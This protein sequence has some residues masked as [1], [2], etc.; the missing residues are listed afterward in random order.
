MTKM[1]LKKVYISRGGGVKA[2]LEKVYILNFFFF[3]MASLNGSMTRSFEPES[4]LDPVLP[5]LAGSGLNQVQIR[6]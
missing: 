1:I 5:D 6:F 4:D 3:F 2:N